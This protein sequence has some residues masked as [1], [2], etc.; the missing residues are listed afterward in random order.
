MLEFHTLLSETNEGGPLMAENGVGPKGLTCHSLWCLL[1]P[2][3]SSPV[4]SLAR[5][6]VTLLRQLRK[7]CDLFS[8]IRFVTL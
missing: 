4:G 8:L 6:R 3:P 7:L 1:E 5:T 2:H